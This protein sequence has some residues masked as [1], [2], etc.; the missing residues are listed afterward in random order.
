MKLNDIVVNVFNE[1]EKSVI[2]ESWLE[3][4][5]DLTEVEDIQNYI[6]DCE[7]LSQ[8]FKTAGPERQQDWEWGWSGNGVTNES[9][10]F[11]NIPYYFKNNTHVRVGNRVYIDNTKYT[12]IRLLRMLQD[13]AFS[14]ISNPETLALIEYGAGTGHN[15]Q[16]LKKKKFK[17]I[18]AADWAQSAVEKMARDGIIKTGNNYRVDYFQESTYQSP[19]EPYVAFTNASLE[20]AGNK[21]QN[22]MEFL[23]NDENLKMG[24]HI[25]PISDL[26]KPT[27]ALNIQSKKYAEQRGY[28]ENFHAFMT[29]QG[30][31]I[32]L[33]KDFE[34]GSRFISGYQMIIWSK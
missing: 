3:A 19:P 27:S 20:Q 30:I 21:Y 5:V 6:N 9:K 31:D 16:Y 8:N 25:E 24:I 7:Q 34:I 15:L 18:Y 29:N 17:E 32:K 12:E 10:E 13:I 14:Y 26:V 33:A 22:F 23:I 4:Q 2:S 1:Q 28:L 11:P